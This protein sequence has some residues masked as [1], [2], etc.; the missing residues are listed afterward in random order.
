MQTN[1]YN[2]LARI[3]TQAEIVHLDENHN[4][5]ERFLPSQ[6][7]KL[8]GKEFLISLNLKL[9]TQ[10]YVYYYNNYWTVVRKDNPANFYLFAQQ[11]P[12]TADRLRSEFLKKEKMRRKKQSKA[13]NGTLNPAQAHSKIKQIKLNIKSHEEI[14]EEPIEETNERINIVIVN[15]P[16]KK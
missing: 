9:C 2:L 8:Y 16:W 11:S 6:I 7:K 1:K 12:E 13:L 14:D 5:I 3:N 10:Q 4:E 15:N